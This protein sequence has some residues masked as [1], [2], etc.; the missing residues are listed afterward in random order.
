[1]AP[2]VRGRKGEFKD[3]LDQLRSAGF[4]ARIDGKKS[5]IFRTAR[6]RS[7]QKSHPSKPPST[8]S[9]S[10]PPNP[11]SQLGAPSYAAFSQRHRVGSKANPQP[12]TSAKPSVEKRPRIR[13]PE[14]SPTRQSASS[15]SASAGGPNAENRNTSSSPHPWPRSRLRTL[16]DV[17]KPWSRAA[18]LQ[19][20]LRCVSRMPRA[21]LAST[22]SIPQKSSQPGPN[23]CSTAA[24]AQAHPRAIRN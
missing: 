17:P 16:L 5:M 2:V 8:A 7:P 10:N 19:L 6:P 24:S 23:P 1:M 12:G 14:S 3:L 13:H 4:R 11:Q 9:S 22:T 15:S 20:H 18:F 21:R